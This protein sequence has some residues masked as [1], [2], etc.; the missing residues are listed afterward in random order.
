MRL[1]SHGRRAASF[2]GHGLPDDVSVSAGWRSLEH[3]TRL[4]DVSMTVTVSEA[5]DALSDALEDTLAERLAAGSL[6]E[7]PRLHVRSAR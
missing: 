1:I 5:A 6:V 3:P 4:A 7:P 2:H